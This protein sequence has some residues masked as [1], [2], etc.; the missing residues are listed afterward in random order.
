MDFCGFDADLF[1][2]LLA[3]TLFFTTLRNSFWIGSYDFS[4]VG[5]R[6]NLGSSVQVAARVYELFLPSTIQS[7][8][9]QGSRL[10][11]CY[12]HCSPRMGCALRAALACAACWLLGCMLCVVHDPVDWLLF[13]VDCLMLLPKTDSLKS[14]IQSTGFILQS[15]V[16]ASWSDF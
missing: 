12:A 6:R 5:L 2:S 7:T 4:K 11:C 13:P 3:T 10:F 8:I 15:T 1:L 14:S 9:L 16:A